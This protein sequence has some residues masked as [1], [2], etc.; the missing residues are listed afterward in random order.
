MLIK[1]VSRMRWIVRVART[2]DDVKECHFTDKDKALKYVEALKKLSMAVD[3]ATVW[4][5]EIDDG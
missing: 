3:D 5:E 2:M 4:M 1:G